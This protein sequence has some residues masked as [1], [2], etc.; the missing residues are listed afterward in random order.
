MTSARDSAT[1]RPSID[2]KNMFFDEEFT[3][4]SKS[5]C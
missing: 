2:A 5:I 4:T 1:E 3:R